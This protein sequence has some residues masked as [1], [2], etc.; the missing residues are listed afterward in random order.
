MSKVES[1]VRK[2][3]ASAADLD[4]PLIAEAGFGDNWGEAH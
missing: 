4:V 3:M 2:L 1:K